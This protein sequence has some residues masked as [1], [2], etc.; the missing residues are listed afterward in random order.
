M[1]YL[2]KYMCMRA[3][4]CIYVLCVYCVLH[5]M[6]VASACVTPHCHSFSIRPSLPEEAVY[7]SVEPVY[8][9]IQVLGDLDLLTWPDAGSVTR[10]FVKLVNILIKHYYKTLYNG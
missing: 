8:Y 4:V 3:R 2:S 9:G 5:G 7:A 1:Q 10:P 6:R